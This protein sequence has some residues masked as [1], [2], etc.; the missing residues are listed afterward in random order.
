MRFHLFAALAR[1]VRPFKKLPGGQINIDFVAGVS[2]P[3]SKNIPL[4]E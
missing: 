2:S 4:R 3:R 1:A